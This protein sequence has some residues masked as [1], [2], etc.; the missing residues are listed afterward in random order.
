MAAPTSSLTNG[1]SLRLSVE[2][3]RAQP[4]G[5]R[6]SLHQLER[7]N[8]QLRATLRLRTAEQFQRFRSSQDMERENEAMTTGLERLKLVLQN[9]EKMVHESQQM[10]EELTGARKNNIAMPTAC[11][12]WEN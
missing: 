5:N 12:T 2:L 7:E 6:D 3:E 1:T 11:D 4:I 8:Q 10:L 9:L